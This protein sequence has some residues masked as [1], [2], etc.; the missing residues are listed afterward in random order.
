MV[1]RTPFFIN[2]NTKISQMKHCAC[3]EYDTV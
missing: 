2:V 1:F 3:L